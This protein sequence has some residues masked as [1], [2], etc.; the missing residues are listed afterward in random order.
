TGPEDTRWYYLAP[1]LLDGPDHTGAWLAALETSLQAD[2]EEENTTSGDRGNKAFTAHMKRLKSY[3]DA[4]TLP[5]LGK[6]P[7]DLIDTL[8][9][10]ALASPAVCIYRANGGNV[11]HATSLAHLFLRYFNTTEATAVVALADSQYQA[12]TA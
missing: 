11:S 8:T 3:L 7:G 6:M 9:N 10:M 1:M 4:E 2:D 12:K 5:M